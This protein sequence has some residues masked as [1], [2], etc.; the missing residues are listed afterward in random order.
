[1]APAAII[2]ETFNK[3]RAENV[4]DEANVSAKNKPRELTIP[5]ISTLALLASVLATKVFMRPV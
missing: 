5:S 4:A 3:S 1:M 2:D